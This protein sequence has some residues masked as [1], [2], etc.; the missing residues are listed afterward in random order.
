[1]HRMRYLVGILTL[2]AAI[3]AAIWIVRLLQQ[4]DD[5]P[6]VM[7]QI[8]F[9]DA[10]GLRAG[11][12]VRFRGVRAGTVRSV[13][14]GDHGSRAVVRALLDPAAAAHARVNTTFWIVTPRFAGITDGATGLD[15][16]VRDAYLAFHTP[17]EPGSRLAEGS[18][19]PGSERPPAATASRKLDDVAPGDLMM[20]VLLPENHGLRAGS[21][22]TFR[23]IATGE[24]R[25]VD[26]APEGTHVTASVRVLRRYRQTVTDATVFW[27]ARPQLSGALFTGFRVDDVSALLSP[28]L[29]YYGESGVGLPVEDHYRTVAQAERP[30]LDVA[31][32][33]PAALARDPEA[34]TATPDG[35]ALV[36][37]VYAA[38]ELDTFSANDPIRVEGSG[39]LYLDRSG[40]PVVVT[41]RSLV[42]GT[43]VERDAFGGDPEVVDEQIK[44]MLESG[45]VVHAGRVWVEPGGADLAALVLT[46]PPPELRGTATELLNFGADGA[47]PDG[48]DPAAVDSGTVSAAGPLYLRRAGADGTALTRE[49]FDRGNPQPIGEHLG[50]AVLADTR[51]VGVYARTLDAPDVPLLV[52]LR[53]LPED[54]R[55]RPE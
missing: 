30:S 19:V 21:P 24:V 8:E 45:A 40:R 11:A 29:S 20:H 53:L 51:V 46:D 22:V 6:G 5:R 18:L 3:A 31:D 4:L 36:R 27:V 52:A 16:L 7:V 37:I 55:P 25:A 32:V 39:V 49:D 43:Y 26:L 41:A 13:R 9:R 2:A 12:D 38:T 33:P 54:L 42:D 1:M 10:R 44:V 15:T 48:V 34:E 14:V 50:A 47:R 35:I 28:Y 17:D 23:G